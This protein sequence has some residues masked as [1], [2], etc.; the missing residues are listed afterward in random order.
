[1]IVQKTSWQKVATFLLLFVVISAVFNVLILSAREL[2][3]GDGLYA[4]GI[5]W[6]SGLA[7]M[8][9][10]KLHG[11][12][13][14]GLG[15]KWP[16][17]RYVWL[18]LLIPLAYAAIAYVLVWTCGLG[19]FPNR[20]F[21]QK[22]VG[23]MGLHAS[24]VASTLLYVAL[25]ASFGLVGSMGRAL[26]EEIGWRGF[27]APELFKSMNFTGATL[28]SA[29]VWALC[30]YPVLIWGD[31]NSGTPSWY[32]LTC[33]TVLILGCSVIANW[34]RLKSGSLWTG[35]ILH[36]SHN[37]F[38]QAIF[39]PLT[40]DTGKSAWFIDEFGVVLPVVIGGF[41][42]YFWRRRHELARL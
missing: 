11:C 24:P 12:S 42:I 2:R 7:A 33:F 38:I 30:H 40:A 23:T 17:I 32:G 8:A 34:M 15:W 1:M 27:L 41:A 25:E 26:G 21:M 35:A 37:L 20:E 19:H 28:F 3:A 13:L 6:A 14:S 5:M 29:A 31:Y 39:T 18:S 10:L 4:T 36:A 9:T 22:L 16:A